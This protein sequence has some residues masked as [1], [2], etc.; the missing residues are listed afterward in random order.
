MANTYTLISSVTVGAG[1]ASSIDFTSIPAT[2]TD[3]QLVVSA[4]ENL[5]ATSAIIY[6]RFNS[7]TGANYSRRR[8]IGD[9]SA[10]SSAS[11]TGETALYLSA[12]ATGTTA[13]ANTFGNASLYIPNYAGSTAKSSSADTVIENNATTAYAILQANLWSGTAAISTITLTGDANFLQYSTA[14]LY[15]IKNS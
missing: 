6:I 10:A 14:Y 11:A 12:A 9:G 8:L 2:Y 7:D 13:T 3:L 5:A 15:G 4:R 1:G